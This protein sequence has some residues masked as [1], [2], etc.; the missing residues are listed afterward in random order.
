MQHLQ[1]ERERLAKEYARQ[2]MQR[3]QSKATFLE[4]RDATHDLLWREF[5]S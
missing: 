5:M 1:S 3:R 4:L 2:R